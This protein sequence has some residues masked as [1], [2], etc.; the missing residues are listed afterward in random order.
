MSQTRGHGRWTADVVPLA[1]LY[2]AQF[3]QIGLVGSVLPVMLRAQGSTLTELASLEIL[4]VLP[5]LK[6]FWA[7]LTDRYGVAR[8]GHY[9]SWVLLLQ[10]LR[11]GSVVALLWVDMDGV[12]GAL[13]LVLFASAVLASTVDTAVDAL[14]FHVA[15][16]TRLMRVNAIQVGAGLLG[17]VLGG[18][19]GLVLL[20]T[21]GFTAALAPTLILLLASIVL[22]TRHRT[23]QDDRAADVSLRR[24]YR[25][26][27]S[28]MASRPARSWVWLQLPLYAVALGGVQ[29]L[30][31]PLLVDSGVD[32]DDIGILVGVVGSLA[33]LVGV[34]AVVAP[35]RTGS[36]PRALV[37]GAGAVLAG[38]TALLAG[39]LGLGVAPVV[40]LA[41]LVHR[42]S[43]GAWSVISNA[44]T[45]GLC[46]RSSAATDYAVITSWMFA[47]SFTGGAVALWVADHTGY[48]LVLACTVIVSGVGALTSLASG[49]SRTTQTT[50]EPNTVDVETA[51]PAP[52]HAVRDRG[53]VR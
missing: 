25:A 34:L 42:S 12:S 5:L 51:D 6:V 2:L 3:A 23:W 21:S 48:G 45:M 16:P 32:A 47:L 17:T 43:S 31:L 50:D 52:S 44:I 37:G 39:A 1:A 22:A 36:D 49:H 14:A 19:A 26:S 53:Q 11:F 27:F 4:L 35:R 20:Q 33:G 18:G 8:W 46:R 15:G 40:V 38:T 24:A 28:L 7:P 10:P 41:F 30:L 29:A 13:L 9:R